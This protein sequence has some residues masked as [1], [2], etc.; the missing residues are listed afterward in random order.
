M[1]TAKQF[2]EKVSERQNPKTCPIRELTETIRYRL[3]CLDKR[4]LPKFDV[5]SILC[6]NTECAFWSKT[7]NGCGLKLMR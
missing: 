4:D 5:E 6:M 1:G 2:V 7:D 3:S